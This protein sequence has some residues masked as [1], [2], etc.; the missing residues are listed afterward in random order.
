MKRLM[1]GVAAAALWAGPAHAHFQ[2]VHTPEVN[3]ARPAEVPF[4]LV[5]W[6]PMDNGYAMDMGEPEAFF[7]VFRGERTDLMDTLEPATFQ[8]AE[9]TAR[10]YKATVP[11]RR[12][13]DYVFVVEPA[14]YYEESEDIF[15]QQITKSYVNRG[16]LPTGWSE[17][18]GVATEIVPLNKPTNVLAGSTFSGVVMGD[19]EPVPGIEVE[20]EY[21]TVEPDVATLSVGEA[22]PVVAEPP[23]GT[24]VAVTD[25]DGRFTFGIP[26]AGFWGFAALGSGP[27]TEHEGK[28][29]SQDA[30][31]WVRA[32]ALQ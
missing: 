21:L 25:A 20:I 28:E 1:L 14:P 30:V 10:A 8:S 16:G 27:E 3:L 7:H 11:V 4:A 12:A 15:I 6:H 2:L 26:R 24:L 13:G 18:V 9:N 17:P 22:E 29:L 31:L 19:G 23:G 32:H 5:F